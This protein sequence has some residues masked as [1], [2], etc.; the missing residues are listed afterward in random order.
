M[1]AALRPTGGGPATPAMRQATMLGRIA[2]VLPAGIALLA[3]LDAALLLLGL[4][5]P[6]TTD[7]MQL[8]HAPLMV[9]G[10]IGTLVILERAV[11]VKH[12]WAFSAPLLS[13]A[14]GIL[15]L[16]EAPLAVGQTGFVLAMIALLFVYGAV[17][18]RQASRAI[19]VQA[20]GAVNGLGAALL[21]LGDVGIPHLAPSM[22]A[23]LVLTI[24]G[25]RIELARI[26]PR[27]NSRAERLGLAAAGVVAASA[28][29]APLWPAA[30]YPLLGAALA[31]L[32][33]W[34]FAYDV[35][36]RLVR[37]TGLPRYAA[38]CLLAGY[39]WLAVA[40]GIWLLSGD[41]TD[42]VAYDAVLHAVFLGFVLSMI[43]A[44][45]PIILPAVLRRK[46]P[47]RPM[48]Y[49]PVLLLHASLLLR[50][51]VGD[52]RGVHAMVQV[53][54]ALNVTAVLLFVVLAVI[55]AVRGGRIISAAAP[56]LRRPEYTDP[57]AG[58]APTPATTDDSTPAHTTP[59]EEPA[60]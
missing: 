50:I 22:A 46:L 39:G 43:M 31:A 15:L 2:L 17:W 48:F 51:A 9:F 16:T 10:F 3:G 29:T 41:P 6:I 38:W 54:G 12:W 55:S 56:A 27:M 23:F 13:G 60:P 32:V 59:T 18:R 14:S 24:V 45:A 28:T 42:G 11:A 58:S 49:V 19:A 47:Y 52:A 4:P 1:T 35:A 44:H 26:S 36:T 53:G 40:A 8:L 25:E 7:R 5:A 20:L 57:T 21:W 33:V 37:A 34:L 30:G